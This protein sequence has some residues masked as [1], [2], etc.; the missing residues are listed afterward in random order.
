MDEARRKCLILL[1]LNYQDEEII[2]LSLLQK[3]E[4]RKGVLPMFKRRKLEGFQ[5]I[6]IRNHLTDNETK[7]KQF[8]RISCYQFNNVLEL[9]RNDL[10]VNPYNRVTEPITASEKLAITLR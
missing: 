2:Q 8:F 6:L 3:R 4:N 7:F 10:T 1:F 5:S 9:I